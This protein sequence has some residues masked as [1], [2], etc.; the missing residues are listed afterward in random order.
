MGRETFS[1]EKASRSSSP[2][3]TGWHRIEEF[4]LSKSAGPRRVHCS[5]VPR[6][7]ER[8]VQGSREEREK[9]EGTETSTAWSVP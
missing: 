7:A 5:Q 1:R 2:S 8:L 9:S 4:G 3:R 6:G